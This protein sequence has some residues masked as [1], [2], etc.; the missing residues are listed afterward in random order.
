ML[1]EPP[2]SP[3]LKTALP[4]SRVDCR[5]QKIGIPVFGQIRIEVVANKCTAKV[6]EVEAV[7]AA[8]P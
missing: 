7:F 1:I 6:A 5:L 2:P 3:Y 4:Q 8:F